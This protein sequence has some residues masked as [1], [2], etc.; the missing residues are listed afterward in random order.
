MSAVPAE[1]PLD[2]GRALDAA[3]AVYRRHFLA[4]VAAMAVVVVPLQ[5]LT[6]APQPWKTIGDV[7]VVFLVSGIAKGIA[8]LVITDVRGGVEPSAVA[9]WRRLRPMLAGL[10]LSVGLAVVV[11]IGSVVLLVVPAILLIVWFEFV[12]QVVVIERKTFFA[13]MGASR[14]LVQ[15]SYWRVAGYVILA[16]VITDVVSVLLAAAPTAVASQFGLHLAATT[17]IGD[18]LKIVA[19]VVVWPVSPLFMSLLY[20]D[21]R[22]RHDGSDIAAMLDAL[23]LPSGAAG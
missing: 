7:L 13:A 20:F 3:L 19:S 9:V 1:R 14:D 4:I 10:V 5:L 8:A 23:A 6:F 11:A 18:M 17:A 21:L 16:L 2:I 15:G 12:G 22:M